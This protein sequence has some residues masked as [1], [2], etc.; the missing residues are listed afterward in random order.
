[1]TEHVEKYLFDANSPYR[2]EDLY[3]IYA[4][5]LSSSEFISAPMREKYARDARLCALNRV[6]TQ[7]TD[8][9]FAD[10][11]GK[12]RML[13]EIK[14]PY[15]LLFFS[16]PG[17]EACMTIINV[18]KGEPR[19]SQMIASR[20][21]AIPVVRETGGLYDSIKPYY[22]MNGKMMGN[23]FTFADYNPYVLA[24]RVFAAI[25]LW[26]NEEK[27]YAFTGKIMRTDFSWQKSATKYLEMY[28]SL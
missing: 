15:T 12:V 11:R 21:G 4:E 8:F 23:G 13:H 25:E 28:N 18:L 19:I 16:N 17:C 2:N 3:G 6:G 26:Q 22:E 1:M 20:Y 24:D 27:R 7:A 5:R 10:K 9:R 14:S